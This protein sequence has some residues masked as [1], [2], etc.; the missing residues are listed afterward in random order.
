MKQFIPDKFVLALLL[1]IGFAWIYPDPGA[2]KTP[3]NLGTVI[4]VGVTLIFFF[5]GLKLSPEKIRSGMGNWRMHLTVQSVTFLVFP[6]VVLPFYPL[7][8]GTEYEPFWLG[9]FF[10]AA[11]PST[12]SSSVVMVSLAGGNIA[13]AIFN[14]SISGI[15]GI[16]ATPLWMGLFLTSHVQGADFSGIVLQ[17]F[18][19]IIVPVVA[20]LLLH[21]FWA[22]WVDK[23]RNQLAMF[24]KATI[25]LIVYES[26]CHSFDS[27][28]FS[29]VGFASLAGLFIAVVALF[30]AVMALTN[31][32]SKWL[33]FK[34]EDHI[35][36]LFC[37]SK[38]SLVHG[39]VMAN[40]LF[41]AMP[42]SGIYLLPIMIFHAFQLFYISLLA[43]RMRIKTAHPVQ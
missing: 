29:S 41:A 27:N 22:R 9:M 5:Y 24:D 14:A 18:I 23:Y 42:G 30:F 10:L 28:A 32:I 8:K 12:V 25:L 15:I 33:N 16:V 19:Q 26:F 40:V 39:T 35:T 1:M 43:K 11:L 3:V 7:F 21:R 6:L 17:L 38:K 34:I 13:G 4:D 20:G 31:Q 2:G 36:I 37:G